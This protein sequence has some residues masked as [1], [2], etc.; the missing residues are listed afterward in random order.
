MT[1]TPRVI[2]VNPSEVNMGYSFI[3]PRWLYVIAQATPQ[4]I[5]GDPII[6]DEVI[7][8]FDAS[9]VMPGDIVGIGINTGNCVSGYRVVREA[10][11]RGAIVI[12]G[13]IHATI[14]P[15]EPL[16][17]GANA[18]VTGNGDLVWRQV[19]E[20]A[21]RGE[22]KT[23]YVGGR[24]PG[25]ALLRA[26]WDLLDP[27]R[28][29]LPSVQTVAGCPE[30]CSFC[31]VWVTDGRQPRERLSSKIIEEVND[32]YSMGYRFIVFADDNFNPATTARIARETSP[33]HR[34][35]LERIRDDRLAFFDEYDRAVPKDMLAFTQM[36]VEVASDDEYFSA[37]YS[38]MRIRTALI[39]IESFSE[40]GLDDANK[41]WSPAGSRMV[42]TIKSIQERGILV[43]GSIICGLESDSVEAM[44]Q[45]SRFAL[46]SGS[47]LAQFTM[48]RPYPGTK[49]YF[50]M[51][52]DR[53]HRAEPGYSPKH[54]SRITGDRF[55]LE[56]HRPV[57]WFQHAGLTSRELVAANK[58]CWDDFYA[59]SE[60][61]RRARKGIASKWPLGGRLAYVFL[62]IVFHRVYAGHGVTADSVQKKRGPLTKL[63][64]RLA[65]SVYSLFFRND[66]LRMRVKRK[67]SVPSR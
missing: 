22:L 12:V 47:A 41:S 26:R 42:E 23:K 55:W 15:E 56:P 18:V 21:I 62:S 20:D 65:I 4:E 51:V 63:F 16:Q 61:V 40:H 6:A 50:E 19:L 14:F 29:L 34:R 53:K 37:M 36:T 33:K 13:G 43:L 5:A 25:D 66:H 24:V 28:Y 54:R 64:I 49:D 60:I 58:N 8:R 52:Q 67:S 7:E 38:K 44:R 11:R 9:T 1:S 59:V 39:G 10:K 46:E 30:N 45:M 2:L 57:D 3:T 48:Y 32:L 27:A 17:M 35:E 31:S